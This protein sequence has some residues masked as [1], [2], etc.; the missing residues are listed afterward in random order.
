MLEGTCKKIEY[1]SDLNTQQSYP[2][3]GLFS[4]PLRIQASYHF[5]PKQNCFSFTTYKYEQ[6][7]L[8]QIQGINNKH[9]RIIMLK[10]DEM[11]R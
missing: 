2:Y 5:P 9:D 3:H 4:K 11:A 6:S 8:K 7:T 1:V 10:Q